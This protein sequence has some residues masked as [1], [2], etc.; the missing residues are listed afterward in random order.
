MAMS[1]RVAVLVSLP[2]SPGAVR[3]LIGRIIPFTGMI[4]PETGMVSV[5]VELR[6]GGA[7]LD[8]NLA[9]PTSA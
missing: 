3:D 9:P 8:I 4:L 7:T 6:R 5:F 1:R 2:K